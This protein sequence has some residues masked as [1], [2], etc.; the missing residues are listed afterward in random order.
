MMENEPAGRRPRV[1]LAPSVAVLLVA[2]GLLLAAVWWGGMRGA[3][4]CLLTAVTLAM[5]CVP[6][7]R[8]REAWLFYLVF[9]AVAVSILRMLTRQG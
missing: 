6:A 4:L 9:L 3:V 5:L 8:R 2:F 7:L 1:P